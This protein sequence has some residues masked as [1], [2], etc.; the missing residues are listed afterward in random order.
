MKILDYLEHYDITIF[1]ISASISILI[2]S[3]AVL[4]SI[5]NKF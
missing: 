4:I 5:I 2:I 3:I 1:A